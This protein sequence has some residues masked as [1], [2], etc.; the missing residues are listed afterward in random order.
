MTGEILFK[1]A[2]QFSTG[3]HDSPTAAFALQ[4]DI[5]AEACDDP[6]VRTAG[7]RFTEA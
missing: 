1:A 4:S 5:R 7:M 2:V 6:F 3:E